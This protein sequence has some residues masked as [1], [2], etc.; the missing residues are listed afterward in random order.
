VASEREMPGSAKLGSRASSI[1]P[2]DSERVGHQPRVVLFAL[3][4]TL[5]LLFSAGLMLA[6][7]SG[8]NFQRVPAG[9]DRPPLY[10][11]I[12]PAAGQIVLPIVAVGFIYHFL[13][14]P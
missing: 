8:P 9:P 2:L 3:L 5:I 11:H 10:M 4:G 7:V 14:R 1:S 13:V 6:C 12:S